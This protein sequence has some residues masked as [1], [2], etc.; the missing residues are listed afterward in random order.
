MLIFSFT[1]EK[2][3]SS[4]LCIT[5]FSSLFFR[6]IIIF[7]LNFQFSVCLCY[8]HLCHFYFFIYVP[9]SFLSLVSSLFSWSNSPT[10]FTSGTFCILYAFLP[11]FLFLLLLLS[12]SSSI[13]FSSLYFSS[14]FSSNFTSY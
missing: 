14:F 3:P 12:Y 5:I 1:V 10:V 2:N 11:S 13:S 7:M 6:Y 8:F 9:L 4:I